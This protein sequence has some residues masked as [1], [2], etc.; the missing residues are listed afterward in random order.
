MNINDGILKTSF[1]A[2]STKQ[3]GINSENNTWER[4]LQKVIGQQ[5]LNHELLSYQNLFGQ[6]STEPA[7][8]HHFSTSVFMQNADVYSDSNIPAY[9]IEIGETSDLNPSEQRHKETVSYESRFKA[10]L[11]ASKTADVFLDKNQSSP[12][13]KQ[14]MALKNS[15]QKVEVTNTIHL[16]LKLSAGATELLSEISKN[17]L[18]LTIDL[19]VGMTGNSG[20]LNTGSSVAIEKYPS[21]LRYPHETTRTSMQNGFLGSV[22][23]VTFSEDEQ[24]SET[25]QTTKAH[26]PGFQGGAS[27]TR[28]PIRLHAEVDQGSIRV[29]IGC[30]VNQENLA[31]AVIQRLQSWIKNTGIAV[32]S[33][34]FN[35]VA[36]DVSNLNKMGKKELQNSDR[37]ANNSFLPSYGMNEIF[38]RFQQNR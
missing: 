31:E 12:Q 30:D 34:F 13:T 1:L 23:A 32:S 22:S 36:F 33:F 37:S 18:Q 16:D 26:Q 27:A 4:E 21:I 5:W 15:Q 17:D 6:H 10:T 38:E 25:S 28:L 20:Q 9:T 2:S 29:W 3:S 8:V 14:T 24:L 11:L 19:N 7:G 35:G